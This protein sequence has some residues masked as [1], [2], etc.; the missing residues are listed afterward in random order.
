MI[1]RFRIT[2]LT[3]LAALAAGGADSARALTTSAGAVRIERIADGL[4]EP[5]SL[6]FLPDA[7]LLVTLRGG[8]L[9]RLPADGSDPVMIRGLPEVFA[10]GQGGLFDVLVPRDFARTGEVLLSYAAALPEG[11]ATAVAVAR[12]DG[13]RLTGLRELWR[14]DDPTPARIH[15]GGRLL[16]LPDGTILLTTGDRGE[17][18]PAQ[19]PDRAR[20]KIV[21]IAR[22]G[23]APPDNPDPAHPYTW[24]LGHRNP[25]GLAIDAQGRVWA[26][27][28]G[29][30]G[31]DEINRIE[32]G[33]NY[34][35]PVISY[36]TNYDGSRIGIGTAA[37]G[38]EQPVRY[39]DPSIAPSGH[40]V[41]SGRL[42]PQWAG[43]HFVGSLKFDSLVRLD[44]DA[45][46][47]PEEVLRDR[48]TG[49]V[50][51]IREGPDGAIWFLSVERGAVFRMTP[52]D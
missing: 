37:P 24:T 43:D 39:W 22:D 47:W 7:D 36:G 49:R 12:L 27:E 4:R 40:M 14:M 8:A 46:G 34:G 31:G 19:D 52:A 48:S 9:V 35:W 44:P 5:W 51:D 50:R 10:E 21:R 11:G 18:M 16:E 26:S 15:F 25:Q 13:D 2:A 17:G 20:G 1:P 3:I 29:A 23:G 33:R 42:W 45:P 41:Y 30:K 28:H 32:P 38:L 6:A